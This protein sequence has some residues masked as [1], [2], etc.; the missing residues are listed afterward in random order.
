MSRWLLAAVCLIAPPVAAQQ[1]S[2][3]LEAVRLATEG[4]GDS[5]RA[6]VTGRL[7]VVSPTDS[8]YAEILYTGGVVSND[9]H[10]ALTYFRRVA[11]EYSNSPWADRALMRLAQISYAG[12]DLDGTI[13]AAERVLV[14]YPLS[15]VR[16]EA[17]FLAAR[18]YLDQ[19]DTQTGCRL[20]D[21]ARNEAG[22]NVEIMNRAAF[23]L[24]RCADVLAADS[25]GGPPPS[26]RPT[27]A[28]GFT[29]QVAAVGNAAAADELMQALERAGY[30]ATVIREEALY[31]VRAGSFRTRNEATE[32][33]AVMR[34][35]F[36]GRPFVVALQ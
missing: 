15:P 19:H 3:M 34:Q 32:F 30:D 35:E 5:A 21:Q 20:L 12:A 2:L 4:R 31:K 26:Q 18:A 17:A 28:A 24:Q 33:A 8:L 7:A 11:I 6:I 22:A 14:D 9:P 13:R 27:Q 25:V 10:A 16:S 29:V 36:G 1:D 23:Y